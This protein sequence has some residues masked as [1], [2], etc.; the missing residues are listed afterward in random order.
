MR[1]V[2]TG[3]TGNIGSA[4]LR[5]LLSADAAH[6]VVGIARRPPD[7]G[8]RSAGDNVSWVALDLTAESSTGALTETFARADAVVHLAWGFQPS[9]DV[10][11]LEA[12]G[13]GGT[14]RVLAAVGAAQVPHLV[15]LSSVGAYSPK[16]SEEPVDETWPTAGVPTSPYSRHK[17]AAERLLDAAERVDPGLVLTRLR[18]G[19]VGQRSAAAR[20]CAT[21]CRASS[22]PGRSA[23][24]RSFPWTGG[25]RFRWST[26]TT[27]RT[28]SSG[29]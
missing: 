17:S 20:C 29:C 15:H 8:D 5:R 22:R 14:R 23:W 21:G 16:Q 13:V 10:G 6:Q 24:C 28:R 3:A 2:V 26:L 4:L 25:W 18:P 9:H 27:S 1:V 7:D 11:Y 19:I 12:L